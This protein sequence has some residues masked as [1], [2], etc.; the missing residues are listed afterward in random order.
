MDTQISIG[1]ITDRVTV[2]KQENGGTTDCMV[3]EQGV[4]ASCT[5]YEHTTVGKQDIKTSFYFNYLPS[6]SE[7]EVM[8]ELWAVSITTVEDISFYPNRK[9]IQTTIN[10]FTPKESKSYATIT[11]CKKKWSVWDANCEATIYTVETIKSVG[12][13]VELCNH[14]DENME[15]T[16]TI[17]TSEGV[18]SDIIIWADGSISESKEYK[19]SKGNVIK[20]VSVNRGDVVSVETSR[21]NED[22]DLIESVLTDHGEDSL[23]IKKDYFYGGGVCVGSNIY[24]D[25]LLEEIATITTT[26]VTL[27]AGDTYPQSKKIVTKKTETKTVQDLHGNLS[28]YDTVIITDTRADKQYVTTS[29]DHQSWF[30]GVLDMKTS[31]TTE[32]IITK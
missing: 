3:W 31:T 12:N 2:T 8:V 13:G 11:E 22:N 30:R 32:N 27:E 6:D 4:L 29:K 17:R 28:I 20:I 24:V 23:T 7:D 5:Q 14:F 16:R 9:N 15:L 18:C 26:D 1:N 10:T 25:G 21:H 19:D